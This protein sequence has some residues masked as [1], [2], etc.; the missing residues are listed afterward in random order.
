MATISWRHKLVLSF[1]LALLIVAV[2][3]LARG[4]ANAAAPR[5]AE[6]GWTV[7]APDG[8][9]VAERFV[10]NE[11]IVPLLLATKMGDVV[12]LSEFPVAAGARSGVRLARGDV[13]APGALVWRVDADGTKEVPRSRLAFLWGEA[14]DDARSRVLMIVD[15]D[16]NEI[17]GYVETAEGWNIMRPDRDAPGEYMLAPSESLLG[18][19]A[20]RLTRECGEETL[21]PI[22]EGASPMLG[23]PPPAGTTAIT[24]LHDATIAVDTDNEL[25]AQKFA[26][27]TTAATNYIASLFAFVSAIY[28][29]DLLVRTKQGTTY[30]RVSSGADPWAQSGTG[31]ADN[32]KLTELRTYWAANYPGVSR[33]STILLSGKQSSA[34]SSSGIAYVDQL[35]NK[36]YGYAFIQVFKFA[37]GTASNDTMVSAHEIG[38]NFG[39]KHT[40]CY[41]TPTPIDT[42]YAGEGSC[43]AG[44]TSCPVP[45]TYSGVS[46]VR[47]TL[48]SYCHTLSG[49][50]LSNVFHPRTVAILAPIVESKVGTCIYPSTA[51]LPTPK[52]ASPA[53]NMRA[54]RAGATSVNVTYTAACGAT[55]HTIYAGSLATLRSQGVVWSQRSCSLGTSG[56]ASFTPGS[57]NVYFVVV[58][59]NGTLEGSYGRASNGT[60]RPAAGAGGACSYTQQLSGTCP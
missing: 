28:E 59:N 6:P 5:V 49:C 7:S 25:M 58:A 47:G 46:N 35:C 38:H 13:Y 31:N 57:G 4:D 15:P 19:A 54:T 37:G 16:K 50:G 29:R 40:H 11:A 20:N 8:A 43:Y 1:G 17:E 27:D 21:D 12:W 2:A 53:G 42:C 24:S 34:Y 26:D 39:S 55:N 23:A 45:A 56:S 14:D 9:S 60:E 30:L 48:M 33:A 52:E 36:S 51:P 18:D 44:A 10:L 32:A 3:P 41:L 22:G